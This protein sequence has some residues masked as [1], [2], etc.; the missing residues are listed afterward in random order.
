MTQDYDATAHSYAL[1]PHELAQPSQ[2]SFAAPPPGP[3][4]SLPTYPAAYAD[5]GGTEAVYADPRAWAGQTSA[6]PFARQPVESAHELVPRQFIPPYP[7]SIITGVPAIALPSAAEFYGAHGGDEGDGH[8]TY[9]AYLS[10][11]SSASY[12]SSG[13]VSPLLANYPQPHPRHP[14]DLLFAQAIPPPSESFPLQWMAPVAGPSTPP[15]LPLPPM[16]LASTS[17]PVA[18]TAVARARNSRKTKSR[19]AVE[20]Q[21]ICARCTT[22]FALLILRGDAHELEGAQ[23]DVAFTCAAC[24]GIETHRRTGAEHANLRKRSQS[25]V[26]TASCDVCWRDVATG[27]VVVAESPHGPADD[28]VF[29]AS[30]TSRRTR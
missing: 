27:S 19:T 29:C 9:E 23:F 13:P 3:H 24:A 18:S 17:A 21:L 4:W 16:P 22:P 26:K 25:V 8:G 6:Y 5:E 12:A 28:I 14:D 15:A 20:T 30:S 7:N 1:S 10:A 2:F 11:P